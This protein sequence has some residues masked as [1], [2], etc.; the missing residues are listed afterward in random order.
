MSQIDFSLSLSVFFIIL[1][2]CISLFACLTWISTSR[3]LLSWKD[4]K[5]RT[6]IEQD[7]PRLSTLTFQFMENLY[8]SPISLSLNIPISYTYKE[9]YM[10]IWFRFCQQK[11]WHLIVE[12]NCLLSHI[13]NWIDFSVFL[14]LF[15]PYLVTLRVSL[16]EKKEHQEKPT[17]S[18]EVL[19]CA[20]TEQELVECMNIV[21]GKIKLER[22]IEAPKLHSQRHHW[23]SKPHLCIRFRLDLAHCHLTRWDEQM[24]KYFRTVLGTGEC[25]AEYVQNTCETIL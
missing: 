13:V 20:P 12:L 24:S 7:M 18:F 3:M 22:Y 15:S 23:Y 4:T 5:Q 25:V 1:T 8:V 10:M 21:H 14:R 9:T 11:S 17:M 2:Q 19:R 16:V 6:A